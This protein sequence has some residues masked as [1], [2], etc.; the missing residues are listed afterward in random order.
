MGTSNSKR[1]VFIV[2]IDKKVNNN[3]NKDYQKD[4]KKCDDFQFYCF[5]NVEE[6]IKCLLDIKFKKTIIITSGSLYQHFY[7]KFQG[8]INQITII[9]K[10]FIFTSNANNFISMYKD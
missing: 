9:P 10:I 2:W 6:G 7:K 4:F 5:D 3:E 8:I 1:N